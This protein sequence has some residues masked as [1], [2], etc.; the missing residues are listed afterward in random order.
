VSDLSLTLL[1]FK[2]KIMPKKLDCIFCKI[3]N[4]EIPVEILYE[5]ET[6]MAFPDIHPMVPVHVLIIPKKHLESVVGLTDTPENEKI[7]GR[8]VMVAKKIAQ[9]KGIQEDGYKLLI[10]TGKH[11]G[12]EIPHIHLHLL[13]GVKMSEG[14]KPIK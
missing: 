5:D 14:I 13:G 2:N 1:K 11:G 10:R 12:Q 6:V 7:M 4:K 3:A 9:E 8:L